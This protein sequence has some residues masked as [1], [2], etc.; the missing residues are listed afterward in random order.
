MDRYVITRHGMNQAN[1]DRQQTKILGTVEATSRDH[2]LDIAES[3]WTCY[4][5]Q[6]FDAS[7]VAETPNNLVNEAYTEDALAGEWDFS[8]YPTSSETF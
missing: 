2:A 7:T 3:K 8:F 1:Q 4:V 6:F 5:N